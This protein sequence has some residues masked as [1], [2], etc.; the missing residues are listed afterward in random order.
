MAD[1]VWKSLVI[2]LKDREKESP[3]LN[4]LRARLDVTMGHGSLEQEILSEMAAALG[5]AGEKVDYNLLRLELADEAIAKASSP[6]ERRRKI[7]AYNKIREDALRA[8]W[9]LKVHREA[10]GF[11]RNRQLEELYPVPPRRRMES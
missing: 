8:R 9:E 5:R 6:V 2:Q 4:R 11:V 3:Y 1:P 10:L 7:Q